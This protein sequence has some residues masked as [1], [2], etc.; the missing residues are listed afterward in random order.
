M[1]RGRRPVQLGQ[2]SATVRIG[3]VDRSTSLLEEG[4][5]EVVDM[6]QCSADS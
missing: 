2:L 3:V 5:V 1:P 4:Q 6:G